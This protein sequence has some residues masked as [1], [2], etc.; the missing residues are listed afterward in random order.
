MIDPT[1]LA[2]LACPRCADRPALA[3]DGDQLVCP[4]CGAR[5]PIVDGIPHLL[6]ESA[7]LPSTTPS[8]DP[9]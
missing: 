4:R 3:L 5:Y 7:I 1:L 6:P 9:S 2:M 8:D